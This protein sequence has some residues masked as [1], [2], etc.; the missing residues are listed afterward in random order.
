MCL[1]Q[2]FLPSLWLACLLILVTLS[3]GELK[4]LIL[5][6][7]SLSVAFMDHVPLMLYLKSPCHTQ[8]YVDILLCFIYRFRFYIQISNFCECEAY[9]VCVVFFPCMCLSGFSTVLFFFFS[10][11]FL[12]KTVFAPL[13]CFCSLVTEQLAVCAWVCF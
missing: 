8:G 11:L 2:I 10:A 7:S 6:K 5:M 1:S 3:F 4:F 9:E 12:E 13:H